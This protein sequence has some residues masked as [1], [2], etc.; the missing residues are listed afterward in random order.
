MPDDEEKASA[1]AGS[2]KEA[3]PGSEPFVDDEL[4]AVAGLRS[5]AQWIASALGAIPGLALLSSLVRAPGDAGFEPWMIIIGVALAAAGALIGVWAFANVMKP[6]EIGDADIPAK[7][8]MDRLGST[9]IPTYAE[10]VTQ[11]HDM[12]SAYER[13]FADANELRADAKE[14]DALAVAA[15]DVATKTE[16]ASLK[17]E[18]NDLLKEAAKAARLT[19][20]N[21]RQTAGEKIGK[22][23]AADTRLAVLARQVA[24]RRR[25]RSD[26]LRLQAGEIVRHRFGEAWKLGS[27]ATALIAAA[28][29][30]LA[31]APKPKIE[32]TPSTEVSLVE[33]RLSDEGRAVLGCH[34][35]S[36]QGIVVGGTSDSPTIVTLPTSTCPSRTIKFPALTS[37]KLGDVIQSE[38]V[39]SEPSSKPS[40]STHSPGG[41]PSASSG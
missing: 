34:A 40:S 10:L 19:A 25:L 31:L 16:A 41:S 15:E 8:K 22:A 21:V 2:A 26:A 5:T 36:V 27:L 14:A 20:T 28:V 7:F 30:L 13:A 29:I 3:P 24:A 33:V 1:S 32:S 35:A 4:H 11:L 9:V 12:E 18:K 37:T 17:D 38:A 39:T 6:A 23:D